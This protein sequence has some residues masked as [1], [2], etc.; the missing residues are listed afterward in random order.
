MGESCCPA[1]PGSYDDWAPCVGAS[2]A[3]DGSVLYSFIQIGRQGAIPPHKYHE[4][5]NYVFLATVGR[6]LSASIMRRIAAAVSASKYLA[7]YA[8]VGFAIAP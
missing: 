6:D 1:L 5:L 2:C 8:G 4:M 3:R 7:R